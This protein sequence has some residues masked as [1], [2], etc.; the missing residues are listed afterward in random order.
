MTGMLGECLSAEFTN[1]PF[2][3]FTDA[4]RHLGGQSNKFFE[5]MIPLKWA[6]CVKKRGVVYASKWLPVINNI[7]LKTSDSTPGKR[8]FISVFVVSKLEAANANFIF[9]DN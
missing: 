4:W 3:K 5:H 8:V 9:K 1:L 6:V 7:V 2:Y